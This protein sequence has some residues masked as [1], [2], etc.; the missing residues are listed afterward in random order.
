LDYDPTFQAAISGKGWV[1]ALTGELEKAI[2]AFNK[3][4]QITLREGITGLG[5]VYALKG[6][7]RQA[8]KYLQEL[9]NLQ[10][11][12]KDLNLNS[13]FAIIYGGL[14]DLDKVFHYLEK[15]I[16]KP[17]SNYIFLSVHPGWKYLRSDPRFVNLIKKAGLPN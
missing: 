2:E 12:E 7:K 16:E 11:T 4:Y 1:F 5:Y 8:E 6:D 17:N 9:L 15:S 3:L 14:R 10:A 13:N